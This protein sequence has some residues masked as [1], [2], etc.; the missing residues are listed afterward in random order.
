MD[1]TSP[2]ALILA[3]QTELWDRLVWQANAAIR[4]RIDAQCRV[5][6]Y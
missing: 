2:M 6:Y 1:S 3:G 5:L 4:Q